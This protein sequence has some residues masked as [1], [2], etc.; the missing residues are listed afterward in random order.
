[1]ARTKWQ[2]GRYHQYEILPASRHVAG[3]FV[4]PNKIIN[5]LPGPRRGG[6]FVK[7]AANVC[8]HSLR[9]KQM[10]VLDEHLINEAGIRH[11]GL[12]NTLRSVVQA[13]LELLP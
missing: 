9:R 7:E 8:I 2:N 6:F 12:W 11:R 1:M 5:M 3:I 10:R 13:V 4:G